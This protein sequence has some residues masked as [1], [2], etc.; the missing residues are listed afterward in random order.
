MKHER[1]VC[2]GSRRI[3][4]SRVLGLLLFVLWWSLTGQL[5]RA[6]STTGDITG[7]VTDSSGAIIPGA[8]VILKNT[9]TQETRSATTS[10]A[11][12]YTF[13]LLGPGTYSIHIEKSGFSPINI[14]DVA[15]AAGDRAREDAKLEVGSAAQTV[16][17]TAQTPALQADSSVLTSTVTEKAVQDLPLDGRNY[18]N[19]AQITPGANEGPPNGLTSGARPD[20]RRQTSSISVNGQSDVINDELVDGMDNNER[21]IGTIG[22]RPSVEA[23]R[24]IN[25]QVILTPPKWAV[26]PAASSTSSPN[27]GPTASM[28]PYMS[29]SA[30]MC[31]MP[32]PFSLERTIVSLSYGRTNLGD[33][34]AVQ[35]SATRHS[36]SEI[37]R[38]CGKFWVKTQ[39]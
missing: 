2:P 14:P 9:A 13:T 28:A 24:E 10:S 6:Q 20:D 37:T 19:L 4:S 26:P 30:T 27:P 38:D 29:S 36:F 15:L 11:G 5:A 16:Q 18:I 12:D 39:W 21:I 31:S 32:T 35:L 33:R 17:V 7:T 23:I 1:C 34:L 3:K 25:V 22:I 8:S